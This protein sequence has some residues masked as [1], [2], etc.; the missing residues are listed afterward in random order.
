MEKEVKLRESE[1]A[2]EGEGARETACRDIYIKKERGMN[3]SGGDLFYFSG[4]IPLFRLSSF[5]KFRSSTAYFL[6]NL[7]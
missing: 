6:C 4:L 2:K 1:R 3:N 5:R 7:W